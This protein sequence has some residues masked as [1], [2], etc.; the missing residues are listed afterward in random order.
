MDNDKGVITNLD[1]LDMWE[2]KRDDDSVHDVEN[3]YTWTAVIGDTEL[4]GTAF[5]EFLA[6]LNNCESDDGITV[7]GGFAGY[8]D[9]VLPDIARLQT[10]L[11]E[12]FLC[13]THPCVDPVFDNG[14]DSFTGASFC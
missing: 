7:S 3:K 9:W 11:L 5:T 14:V 4:N 12:P 1:T 8:C 2:I 13:S 6:E 10:I